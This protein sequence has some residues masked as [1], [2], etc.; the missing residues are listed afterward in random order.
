MSESS[1]GRTFD[2]AGAPATRGRWRR[3]ARITFLCLIPVAVLAGFFLSRSVMQAQESARRSNC[4]CG[5]KQFGL[6]LHNYHET[7][8]TFPPA[9]VLGPDG[10]PWHSWRVLIL[11][12]LECDPLYQ[13]YRFA[14]PWDGPNNRKLL[15]RMPTIF[16]CPSRPY[17]AKAD[18]L[19]TMSFGLLACD[20]HPLSAR[21]GNTSYAAVLGQD[22]AFRGTVAVT[23]KDI[24][25]GT[26]NTALIGESNRTKIPWTKP[27]DIDI[28]FHPKLGDPDGFSSYHDQGCHFLRGDGTVKFLRYDLPKATVDAVFTRNG[29]ETVNID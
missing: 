29:G 4:S 13:E 8:G 15:S 3:L 26:S 19:A 9:F 14:E 27:E 17:T 2:T 21:D 12:Y 11:P 28:A 10:Q 20:A 1:S 7:Y 22:C 24:T 23:I 6:A 5:L 25:D 18:L 16:A